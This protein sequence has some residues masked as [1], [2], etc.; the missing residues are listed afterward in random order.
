MPQRS[1]IHHGTRRRSAGAA[2]LAVALLVAGCVSGGGG[3]ERSLE[4]ILG[5]DLDGDGRVTINGVPNDV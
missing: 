1:P 5:R 2:S 3:R 4:E